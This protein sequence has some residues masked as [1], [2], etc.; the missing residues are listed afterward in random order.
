MHFNGI[1]MV[2]HF[3]RG[4]LDPERDL[5][6]APYVLSGGTLERI[7][8]TRIEEGSMASYTFKS[9][10]KLDDEDDILILPRSAG[11]LSAR[12]SRYQVD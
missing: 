5:A 6:E 2:S 7:H 1:L 9:I 10:R 3:G 12:K 4:L 8:V 11:E